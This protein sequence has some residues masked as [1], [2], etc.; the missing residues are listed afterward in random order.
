M[1]LVQPT[2]TVNITIPPPAPIVA[3]KDSYTAAFGQPYSP[4]AGLSLLA[5]DSSPNA[6]PQLVVLANGPLSNTSAGTLNVSANGNFT[7]VPAPGWYG[8]VTFP[9]TMT[10]QGTGLNATATAQIT[11][12]KPLAP[13]ATDDRYTCVWGAASCSVPAG[14]GLLLNDTSPSGAPIVVVGAPTPS[15]GTLSV[16]PNGSFT[17]LPPSP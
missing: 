3:R 7:F 10:D 4:P 11:I 12:P 16:S 2:A 13:V 15:A 8:T 5:N 14:Q 1:S 6:N 9:Y 17:W